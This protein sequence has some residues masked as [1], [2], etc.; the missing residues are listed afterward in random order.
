MPAM[1]AGLAEGVWSSLEELRA[2]DTSTEVFVPGPGQRRANA[3]HVA[4]LAALERARHWEPNSRDPA[5][6]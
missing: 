4:W 1:L 6:S 2:I 5:G 3:D